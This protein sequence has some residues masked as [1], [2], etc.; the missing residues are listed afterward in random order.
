VLILGEAQLRTFIAEYV[1]FYNQARP[2]QSLSHEQPV[3]R[4]VDKRGRVRAIP[5]VGGLHHDYRRAA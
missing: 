4:A 3:P 2:H 5:V 1:R